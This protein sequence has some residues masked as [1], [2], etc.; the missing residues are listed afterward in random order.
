MS[1]RLHWQ[2]RAFLI[3]GTGIVLMLAGLQARGQQAASSPSGD[4]KVS[5]AAPGASSEATPADPAK[6]QSEYV[7]GPGDLLAIN[8]WNE[9]EVTGKVPVRT[10]GKITVPLVGEIQAGG[11]TPS[12]LQATLAQ[13]LNEFV[14]QPAVTVVV[15]EMNSRQFNVL[16]EVEHPGSYP[17]TRP[18][19][20]IDGLA[21]AG[22]F[23]D[24]AKVKKIYVL[25][26]GPSGATVKLP[27]NYKDVTNG[28]ADQDN[29]E[30][31]PGDSI[32][33]P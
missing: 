3:L 24:F 32:I 9:P 22:G 23:R 27:F 12:G 31:Q 7:I 18:T 5:R 4:S 13:K 26:K 19:K 10:D 17:L 6:A 11:K 16:G 33:V 29:V 2:R 28:K 1:S 30:L 25:R 15:E 14:K 20:V 21:L 8:V